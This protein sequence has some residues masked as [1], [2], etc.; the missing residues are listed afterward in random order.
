VQP[1]SPAV[2]HDRIALP[3][4]VPEASVTAVG[5]TLTLTGSG[6]MPD[7]ALPRIRVLIV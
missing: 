6:Q 5:E 4:E 3:G 2:F 7:A 1:L